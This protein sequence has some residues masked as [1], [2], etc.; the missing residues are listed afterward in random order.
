MSNS[1]M[2]S[3]YFQT[4]VNQANQI[5]ECY[6][7]GSRC[8]Q[9]V[10][11]NLPTDLTLSSLTVT[12]KATIL[13]LIDPTGLEFTPVTTNP[14]G[15]QA[16]TIWVNSTDANNLYFGASPITGGSGGVNSVTAGTNISTSGT[17]T[18]PI[19]NFAPGGT[20]NMNGA[21]LTSV[22]TL[23]VSS[24]SNVS[25]IDNSSGSNISLTM[26]STILKVEDQ[27]RVS[28][29]APGG[30]VLGITADDGYG[31]GDV[32]IIAEDGYG[33]TMKGGIVSVGTT[34]PSGT[35]TVGVNS[36]ATKLYLQPNGGNGI[37]TLE[38]EG[39]GTT[40]ITSRTVN[41]GD[42]AST[43]N[44]TVLSLADAT[45]VATLT[46]ANNANVIM[47][48]QNTGG[49]YGQLT[50][51]EIGGFMAVQAESGYNLL[52]ES[53][54]GSVNIATANPD[55]TITASVNGGLAQITL[56]DTGG[57]G[58]VVLSAGNL[59]NT[60]KQ[61]ATT[62]EITGDSGS[63]TPATL[64]FTDATIGNATA[65]YRMDGFGFGVKEIALD[66]SLFS[67]SSGA[68][69]GVSIGT[70]FAENLVIGN[71]LPLKI[72]QSLTQFPTNYIELNNN[73]ITMVT[74]TGVSIN[75]GAV[76]E[77][78][79]LATADGLG[80]GTVSISAS[81]NGGT[82]TGNINVSPA[83]VRA[84]SSDFLQLQSLSGGYLYIDNSGISVYAIAGNIDIS[85]TNVP[86]S[87]IN[88]NASNTI[89]L[90][91]P[92]LA[93]DN[94]PTT[95]GTGNTVGIQANSIGQTITN[96]LKVLY[97]GSYIWIP[98]LTSDPSV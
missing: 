79:V 78:Q 70:N 67:V 85:A 52:M 94:I 87:N 23:S 38:A 41:I 48:L 64:Q 2:K 72:T 55:T 24:I 66:T 33:L 98:Y 32:K 7:C 68:N 82:N 58:D 14:G 35:V 31:D 1:Y 71:G 92:E 37:I 77:A 50:A 75:V 63:G 29:T 8:N 22:S 86:T 13:G 91:S 88:L 20:M 47:R 51:S 5:K 6:P 60:L 57:V 59:V 54:G 89:K 42:N 3:A 93:I 28:I 96:Y 39:T 61:T 80:N 84:T 4:Q 19:I 16:N 34:I 26:P 65:T 27:G 46:N 21:Q 90:S 76:T 81:G 10:T 49:K 36:D 74:S 69:E 11:Y 83:D 40:N 97:N 15:V 95:T 62:T 25:L 45:Q 44:G 53:T 17:A 12:G 56:T 9:I 30:A 73:N 18:D 43:V